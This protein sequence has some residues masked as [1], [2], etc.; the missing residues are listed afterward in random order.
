VTDL[1]SLPGSDN[2]GDASLR[3]ACEEHADSH[4]TGHLEPHE[5][6][7]LGDLLSDAIGSNQVTL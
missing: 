4:A 1:P 6:E 7:M 2:P 3:H 5:R